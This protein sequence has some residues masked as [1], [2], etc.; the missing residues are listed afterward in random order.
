MKIETKLNR[1]YS[2]WLSYG[3]AV[4]VLAIDYYTG[5]NIDFPIL[6]VLPIGLAGFS[7]EKIAAYFLSVTLPAA[8][9]GFHFLWHDNKL[10]HVNLANVL[11]MICSLYLYVYLIEKIVQH[12]QA[13]EMKVDVLEGVLPICASCKRIRNEKGNMN[14]LSI[15]SQHIQALHLRMAYV[16]SV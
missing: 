10:L 15:T 13:L 16:Q 1:P 4:L 14:K 11:I 12:T 9:F 7:R 8:R 3:L 5:K 6:Y 2:I